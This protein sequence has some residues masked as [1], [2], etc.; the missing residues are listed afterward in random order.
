MAKVVSGERS[1][2]LT[3]L[4]KRASRSRRV[5]SWLTISLKDSVSCWTSRSAPVT[6][7]RVESA[8]SA[9]SAAAKETSSRGRTARRVTQ[10]PPLIPMIE[11]NSAP[12]PRTK[13]RTR[14]VCSRLSSLKTSKTWVST[15]GIGTPT[16]KMISPFTLRV[17]SVACPALTSLMMSDETYLVEA[18]SLRAS[19]WWWV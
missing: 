14:K 18:T 6:T 15:A 17:C 2:W 7:R 10:S 19:H 9:I 12:R 11:V 8:P 16:T 1:S 3:S 13:S 4:A 5:T